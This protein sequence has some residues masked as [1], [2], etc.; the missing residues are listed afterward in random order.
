MEV[1]IRVDFGQVLGVLCGLALFGVGY[2]Q[3]V[4]AAERRGWLE[5]FV[6][7]AVALG[8]A[9]TLLGAAAICWQAAVL[10][11][12]CFVASGLPM[13]AGSIWRYVRAR[14]L[15]IRALREGVGDGNQTPGLG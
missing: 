2:N 7:L 13:I 11:L 10:V 3:A 15:G 12:G 14:E 5:G 8:A 9:V 6:S 4:A 1:V